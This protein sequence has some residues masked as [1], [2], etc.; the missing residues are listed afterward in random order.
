MAMVECLAFIAANRW[1]DSKASLQSAYEVAAIWCWPTFIQM[2]K[3]NS[4]T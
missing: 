1:N 2:T 3:V 4:H